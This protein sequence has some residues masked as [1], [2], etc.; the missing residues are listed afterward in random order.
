MSAAA[1]IDEL[2]RRGASAWRLGDRVRV[3]PALA[4]SPDLA[5]AVRVHRAELLALLPPAPPEVAALPAQ[6]PAVPDAPTPPRTWILGGGTDRELRL[7]VASEPPWSERVHAAARLVERIDDLHRA[8]LDREAERAAIELEGL[9]AEL[10]RDGIVAW[11]T[12]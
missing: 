11:L 5:A 4:V 2:R 3:C 8:S 10:R 12:S 1:I 7:A 6:P 9:L